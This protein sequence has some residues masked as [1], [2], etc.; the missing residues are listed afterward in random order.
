MVAF[1]SFR[2]IFE[3]FVDIDGFHP[4]Y[5]QYDKHPEE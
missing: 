5:S 4:A 2:E 1:H 3:L